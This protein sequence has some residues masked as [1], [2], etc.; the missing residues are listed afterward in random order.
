MTAAFLSLRIIRVPVQHIVVAG[1][2]LLF[3]TRGRQDAG[4][5]DGRIVDASTPTDVATGDLLSAGFAADN[6]VM[7]VYFLVLFALPGSAF[8][9]R[10]LGERRVPADGH[11]LDEDAA[12]HAPP[13]TLHG[14]ADALGAVVAVFGSASNTYVILFSALAVF[15]AVA[16]RVN[17]ERHRDMI[18]YVVATVMVMGQQIMPDRAGMVSGLLVGLGLGTGGV[19]AAVLGVIADHYGVTTVLYIITVLPVLSA[20][21]ACFVPSSHPAD[22]ARAEA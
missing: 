6:L 1:L 16:V 14:M 3:P 5:T 21:I 15:T 8:M 11:E 20:F 19:G 7:A 22:A 10:W 17:A 4:A 12:H 2:R 13:P 9:R 18:G